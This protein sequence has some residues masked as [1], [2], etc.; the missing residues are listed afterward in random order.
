MNVYQIQ[1]VLFFPNN[2]P[3]RF[4]QI[5]IQSMAEAHYSS[6]CVIVANDTNM[7]F[8]L[9]KEKGINYAGMC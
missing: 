3:L 5:F 8:Y 9:K 1:N 6:W 4:R 7:V 2:L